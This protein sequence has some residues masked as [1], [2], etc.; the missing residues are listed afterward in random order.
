MAS[1]RMFCFDVLQGEEF[2]QLSFAGQALYS[3]LAMCAD[4][5][6][7]VSGVQDLLRSMRC[8][9]RHLMELVDAGF[10]LEVLQKVVITHWKQHNAIP[11]SRK[12]PTRYPKVLEQLRV[13]STDAYELIDA[14]SLQTNACKVEDS[15][16]QPCIQTAAQTRLDQIRTEENRK[17]EY[18][19]DEDRQ[20]DAGREN[21]SCQSAGQSIDG[22]A[23]SV[24]SLYQKHC[25]SLMPCLYLSE[26]I[27]HKIMGLKGYGVTL[28]Q[29]ESVF[30]L[31]EDTPFLRGEGEKGWR[32][33]LDWLCS[34][35]NLRR[36]QSGAYAPRKS[37]ETT[38]FGCT[39][40]GQAEIE[41]I[42]KLLAEE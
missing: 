17:V 31:A 40:L 37:K 1:K 28:E 11:P 6:G 16:Q 24:F 23:E 36:V 41:A 2:Y 7:I 38:V 10:V 27:R 13:N 35:D 15:C 33:S 22:F 29:I 3:R 25:K 21:L 19:T 9:K 39:G 4:D 12:K 32:A 42:Q 30:R 8:N 18:R 26:E 20:E 34:G 14:D 5:D